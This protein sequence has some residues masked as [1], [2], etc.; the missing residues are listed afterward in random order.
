M[1]DESG[2]L[3]VYVRAF[4]DAEGQMKVSEGGGIEPVWAPNGTAIYYLNGRT[5]MRASVT[6]EGF[7]EPQMLFEGT[8]VYSG[9]GFPGTNVP[10][11]TNWGCTPG[12][13]VVRVCPEPRG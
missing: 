7:G 3:E 12:R 8:W 4:P 1:S 9:S 10:F 2:I 6:T 11:G 5:V 13:H